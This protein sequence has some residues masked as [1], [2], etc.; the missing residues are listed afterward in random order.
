MNF[1]VYHSLRTRLIIFL[2]VAL[3][4]TSGPT[5]YFYYKSSQKNIKDKSSD[6]IVTSMAHITGQFNDT[7][8]NLYKN[9]LVLTT[10]RD[11]WNILRD[12]RLQEENSDGLRWV[13]NQISTFR[14]LNAQ[15]ESTFLLDFERRYVVSSAEGAV[16]ADENARV[17]EYIDFMFDADN[18]VMSNKFILA[19]DDGRYYKQFTG[20]RGRPD[21][22]AIIVPIRNMVFG[23]P[24]GIMVINLADTAIANIFR[25]TR[26]ADGSVIYLVDRIGQTVA[27]NDGT[28][29]GVAIP[30]PFLL[31]EGEQSDIVSFGK[32][33][34]L[35]T[36]TPTDFNGWRFVSATPFHNLTN[37]NENALK[38]VFSY[39]LLA[40]LVTA[41]LLIVLIERFFYKPIYLLLRE[42]RLRND[43][44]RQVPQTLSRFEK[45]R[46]E[47]GYMFR[48]FN[49]IL[50]DKERLLNQAYRQKLLIGETKL[51][52]LYSQINPHFLYNTLDNIRWLAMKFTGGHNE[53]SRTLHSL[54]GIL[55][56]SVH[57][58]NPVVTVEEELHFLDMYLGIQKVRYGDKLQVSWDIQEGVRIEKMLKFILQPLLENAIEHGFAAA[59]NDV[60]I[61]VAIAAEDG[62]LRIRVAD[63]GAGLSADK[64]A[65]AHALI[66]GETT[67][68][69]KGIGLRNIYERIRLYYGARAELSIAGTEGT[70]TTVTLVLPNAGGERHV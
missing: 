39:L 1:R 10:N 11:L 57:S 26:Y 61:S 23:A 37:N 42:I 17:A 21:S 30:Q 44:E 54:S 50:A 69:S 70:G 18:D 19:K 33:S 5:L 9:M 32:K 65:Y 34:Y 56:N 15:I 68:D 49:A 3:V 52:A 40:L 59:E 24:L 47:V 41:T 25:D 43:G 31:A 13:R 66:Q 46:D 2:L 16:S 14:T 45:R 62:A 6:F 29:T 53:V 36:N 8:Q 51:R 60:C 64:L 58:D 28:A 20:T 27:A 4:L 35:V 38:L 48:S 63:N 22:F 7:I 55:R 12:G 67:S